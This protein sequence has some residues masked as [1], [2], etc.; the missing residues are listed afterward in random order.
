VLQA[1]R[2]LY[3]GAP[4][5]GLDILFH[6]RLVPSIYG[7]TLIRRSWV[8]LAIASCRNCPRVPSPNKYLRE[9][10]YLCQE[11]R[12]RPTEDAREPYD[13]DGQERNILFASALERHNPPPAYSEHPPDSF[14][15]TVDYPLHL[16]GMYRTGRWRLLPQTAADAEH[17]D[18]ETELERFTREVLNP[19]LSRLWE[20]QD[21]H[22]SDPDCD[23][24][25]AGDLDCTSDIESCSGHENDKEKPVDQS[26]IHQ[27]SEEVSEK[28][29]ATN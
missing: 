25:S 11:A 16:E 20:M 19:A 2:L 3:Y 28:S 18:L 15:E 13:F 26:L 6:L 8:C 9:S 17:K 24:S 10:W 27:P 7:M 1:A 21:D 23:N 12:L 4:E 14:P 5:P 29:L 22:L